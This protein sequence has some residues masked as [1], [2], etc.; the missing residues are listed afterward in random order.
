[1]K[2][3]LQK[4]TDV[5]SPSGYEDAIRTEIRNQV[6]GFADDVRVDAFTAVC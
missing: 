6:R 3:L 5:F 4:L 2:Q 1:M